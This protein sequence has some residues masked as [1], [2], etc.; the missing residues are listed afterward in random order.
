VNDVRLPFIPR[1]FETTMEPA[2]I[3]A[4]ST[5]TVTGRCIRPGRARCSECCRL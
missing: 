1:E 3:L 4:A 5:E 2:A